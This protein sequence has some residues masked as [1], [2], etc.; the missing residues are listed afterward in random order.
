M[1]AQHQGFGHLCRQN[2]QCQARSPRSP[3]PF[4]QGRPY[5]EQQGEC[6]CSVGPLRKAGL[7]PVHCK[8]QDFIQLLPWGWKGQAEPFPLAAVGR[9]TC[10]LPQ[11]PYL[12]GACSPALQNTWQLSWL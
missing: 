12:L 9:D 8:L 1:V 2:R 7:H 4:I 10:H 5:P 3:A 6:L 11:A